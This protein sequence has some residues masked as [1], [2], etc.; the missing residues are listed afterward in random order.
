MIKL[1]YPLLLFT[2]LLNIQNCSF[3]NSNNSEY[4][5]TN[6]EIVRTVNRDV[7]NQI[8]LNPN[9]VISN[10]GCF[11]ASAISN[12]VDEQNAQVARSEF[13]LPSDMRYNKAQFIIDLKNT[14]QLN[15][16]S[17]FEL[18]GS[19]RGKDT[20]FIYT[21]NPT[22]W[23][24]NGFVTTK[25]DKDQWSSINLSD[26]SRFVMLAFN[27]KIKDIEEV[28]L[29]GNEIRKGILD[30]SIA[31]VKL[32]KPTMGQ[33][34]GATGGLW[35]NENLMQCVSSLREFHS[36]NWNDGGFD[37][38]NIGFPVPNYPPF[39]NNYYLFNPDYSN[40]HTDE[41]YKRLTNAGIELN[42][43]LQTSAYYITQGKNEN[44]KPVFPNDDPNNPE[45][46]KAHADYMYQYTARYGKCKVDDKNLKLYKKS[47]GPLKEFQPRV[48]GLN[49]VKSIENW[50]E[51]D[52]WWHD[53]N[54]T[55]TPFQFA[56]MTSADFDGHEKKLGKTF[57]IKNADST[58]KVVMG[59][60]AT[61][62][63][64]FIKGMKLW[65]EFFRTNSKSFPA[66]VLNFHHYSNKFVYGQPTIGISPEEDLLKNKLKKI[67]AYRDSFLPDKEIWLSEF[68]YDT[69]EGSTQ[70]APSIGNL[71]TEEIQGRWLL[72]SFLEIA[73]SGIDRAFVY[74]L[75]DYGSN[76]TI[77]YLTSGLVKTAP[78][79]EK[80]ISW[81][82]IAG[83]KSLLKNYY[84]EKEVPSGKSEINIY[85]FKSKNSTKTIYAIWCNTSKNLEITNY[86][87]NV[88]G[89]EN[90]L[91][92]YPIA[93]NVFHNK[94]SIKSSSSFFEINKVTELPLFI[95]IN[96]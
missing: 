30:S 29:Y 81:Y 87:F 78:N 55:F 66:D 18:A 25:R 73:A 3:G 89:N 23:K 12:L 17:L 4:S 15:K 45:S 46:Y 36:W 51:P 74:N 80:K 38:K 85:A 72:R 69:Q 83:L 24:L 60:L 40:R 88:K 31:K 75:D 47:Y 84:F 95:E 62:N 6:N 44:V 5:F 20:I 58:M 22:K 35:E 7:N 90:A 43:C 2:L 96:N 13:I 34:M 53:N 33:L 21:G 14:Y 63:I 86:K 10:C 42:P 92:Y 19:W 77:Q 54:A 93:K 61:L 28:V 64:D 1:S 49:L 91:L 37:E 71:N 41:D 50:N 76:T 16:I 59:G 65:S 27:I 39:P 9:M 70:A 56:A 79:N 57:G 32:Q 48:S 11:G 67:V 94:I 8:V 68:G 52:K 82:Y 26:S